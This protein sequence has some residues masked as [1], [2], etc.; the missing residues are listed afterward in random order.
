MKPMNY[1]CSFVLAVSILLAQGLQLHSHVYDNVSAESDH[2]HQTISHFDH[3]VEQGEAHPDES[4]P[5]ETVKIGLKKSNSFQILSAVISS[6]ADVLV[7][8]HLRSRQQVVFEFRAVSNFDLG[9]APPP[10][11]PPL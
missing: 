5:I 9:L 6:R 7:R 8:S 3:F 4:E 2:T 11:A 10:R 1:I